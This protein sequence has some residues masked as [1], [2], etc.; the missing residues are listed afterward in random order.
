M[1]LW[2]GRFP[3]WTEEKGAAQ[4]SLHPTSPVTIPWIIPLCRSFGVQDE[5]QPCKTR[6]LYQTTVVSLESWLDEWKGHWIP[7]ELCSCPEVRLRTCSGRVYLHAHVFS[8]KV[9]IRYYRWARLCLPIRCMWLCLISCHAGECACVDIYYIPSCTTWLLWLVNLRGLI[10]SLSWLYWLVRGFVIAVF[11]EAAKEHQINNTRQ[12]SCNVEPEVF[13]GSRRGCCSSGGGKCEVKSF[14]PSGQEAMK[15][16]TET[17]EASSSLCPCLACGSLHKSSGGILPHPAPTRT[18]TFTS[19][20]G[21]S[22]WRAHY[23]SESPRGAWFSS[24]VA[25][26]WL[27]FDQW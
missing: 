17:K 4:V 13:K 10:L 3:D 24:P 9:C 7:L 26:L 27:L 14:H 21:G 8:S 16:E 15:I 6:L 18:A 25:F 2:N 5:I 12:E 11:Y 22:L 23:A 1:L 19:L 20:K